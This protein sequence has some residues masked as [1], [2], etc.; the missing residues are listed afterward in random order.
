VRR[1]IVDGYDAPGVHAELHAA[2]YEAR[3]T[4]TADPG[5][6]RQKTGD[7]EYDA[8]PLDAATVSAILFG[9]VD[10]ETYDRVMSA[11]WQEQYNGRIPG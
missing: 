6:L 8:R 11:K 4:R 5:G 9:V 10:D 2:F 7:E 1:V 3:D